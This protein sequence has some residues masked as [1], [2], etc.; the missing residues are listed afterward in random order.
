MALNNCPECGHVMSSDADA[1]PNCGWKTTSTKVKEA[2][3]A[4][5]GCGA[6]MTIFITIPIVLVFIFM[7][8]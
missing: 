8:L 2:G 5:T 3:D 4:M 6:V 1:C 7:G